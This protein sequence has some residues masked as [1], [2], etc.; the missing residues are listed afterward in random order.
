M[1]KPNNNSGKIEALRRCGHGMRLEVL[2]Q[3][4]QIEGPVLQRQLQIEREQSQQN[5]Q[6]PQAQVKS[7]LE[8]GKVFIFTPA[9][10]PNHDKGRHQGQFMEEVKEKQ[11]QRGKGAQDAAAHEEQ[12]NVKLLLA[13][14]D[15][16]R[17]AHRGKH[18]H[19]AHENQSE[20]DP[21]HPDVIADPQRPD[22]VL[23]LHKLKT[24]RRLVAVKLTEHHHRQNERGERCQ[25]RD[26]PYDK[27]EIPRYEQNEQRG[28]HRQEENVGQG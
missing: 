1:P 10:H 9:P 7:N 2:R 26:A 28:Q 8:R 21:V 20:V 6:R 25:Q 17:N 14:F 23:L 19:R 15:L 24:V 13:R 16:A 11:I 18:H 5:Q 12:Q 3:P 22:P 27:A 4:F